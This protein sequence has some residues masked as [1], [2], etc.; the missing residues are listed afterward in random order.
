MAYSLVV[1][2]S[3]FR[4]PLPPNLKYEVEVKYRPSIPNNAKHWKV[5]ED[6]LEIKIFLESVDNFYSLHI[7]QD[8]DIK[9]LMMII[10]K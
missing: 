10:S 4:V 9:S 5:F 8:H 1:L 6:D 7:D 2:A 3:L